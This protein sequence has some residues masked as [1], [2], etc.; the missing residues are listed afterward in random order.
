MEQ[1]CD[2]YDC[3]LQFFPQNVFHWCTRGFVD[4]SSC[5]SYSYDQRLVWKT[6]QWS[7]S[8]VNKFLKHRKE[9][10]S[11]AF[12]D[13]ERVTEM[14]GFAFCGECREGKEFTTYAE[15]KARVDRGEFKWC[16]YYNKP[17]SC[18]DVYFNDRQMLSF[19]VVQA[20]LQ[21]AQ[22]NIYYHLPIIYF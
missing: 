12:E 11:D 18:L 10:C 21:T 4:I 15:L 1:S 22:Y 3:Q 2:G 20:L 8:P 5:R 16:W 9:G 7:L 19:T 13:P 6:R 17:N 14:F